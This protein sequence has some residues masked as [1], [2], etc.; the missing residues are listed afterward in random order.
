MQDNQRRLVSN[1]YFVNE[2]KKMKEEIDNARDRVDRLFQESARPATAVPSPDG[3]T[4]RN[5]LQKVHP[6]HRIRNE[7]QSRR[8]ARQGPD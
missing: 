1:T 3:T 6:V 5:I 2:M 7:R 8:R 4:V